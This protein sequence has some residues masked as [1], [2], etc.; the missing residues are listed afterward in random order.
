MSLTMIITHGVL[1]CLYVNV[2]GIRCRKYYCFSILMTI[3][4]PL[5]YKAVSVSTTVFHDLDSVDT[6]LEELY[7]VAAF[8]KVVPT[9]I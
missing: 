2:I 9:S 8:Y 4:V 1:A 7:V 5:L 3:I 6:D